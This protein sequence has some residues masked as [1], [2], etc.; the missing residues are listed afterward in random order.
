M[1]SDGEGSTP[2]PPLTQFKKAV[3]TML[4]L[5]VSTLFIKVWLSVELIFAS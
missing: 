3:Q 1:D 4:T 5:S 2:C